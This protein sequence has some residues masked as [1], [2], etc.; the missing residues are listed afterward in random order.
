[1]TGLPGCPYE[2]LCECVG[3]GCPLQPALSSSWLV[4]VEV[5][6]APRLLLVQGNSVARPPFELCSFSSS[7][8]GRHSAAVSSLSPG[9]W[10]F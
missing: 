6:T 7:E 5:I 8:P 9:L 3:L 1:M 2:L 10:S 4:L